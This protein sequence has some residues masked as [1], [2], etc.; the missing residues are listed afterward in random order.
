MERKGIQDYVVVDCNIDVKGVPQDCK[1]V[2]TTNVGFNAAT[3]AAA[4]HRR[5][6]ANVPGALPVSHNIFTLEFRIGR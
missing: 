2:S 6:R 4:T 1:T 3:L 5:F